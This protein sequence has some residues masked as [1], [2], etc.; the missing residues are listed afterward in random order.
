M[1]ITFADHTAVTPEG[2]PVAVPIPVAFAV[3]CIIFVNGVLIHK[4]GELEAAFAVISGLTVIVP[5]AFTMPQSP[6]KGIE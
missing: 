2:K 3:L 4:L 5:V 6:V 1:V